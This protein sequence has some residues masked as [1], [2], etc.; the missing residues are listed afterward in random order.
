MPNFII[1]LLICSVAMSILALVYIAIIPLL[2]K[3]YSEK[4]CY[5]AW[6]VIVV[7]LIIPFRPQWGN[8][9]VSVEIPNNAAPLNIVQMNS[10]AATN[11]FSPIKLPSL[12][13]VEN[14]KITETALNFS[15]WQI[16]AAVWLIGL[17]MFVVY[18]SVKHY[19]FIKM[20][21]R[22]SKAITDEYMLSSLKSL[23]SEMGITKRI[24]IYLCSCVGSPV[25]IGLFNPCIFFPTVELAQDEICFILKHE[26][27]HYKRKDLLYKYLV[28]AATAIHWFNP[29]V[30]IIARTINILC[31]MSCDAAVVQSTDM[32]TRQSYSET[33][34]GVVKYHS[35]LKTALSTN[36]YGGRKGVIKRFLSIMDTRKKKMGAE[37]VCV[38]LALTVGTGFLFAVTLGSETL[39]VNEPID[40]AEIS[41]TEGTSVLYETEILNN[42][43][44]GNNLPY[45]DDPS[46]ASEVPVAQPEFQSPYRIAASLED[47]KVIWALQD[48]TIPVTN[49]E[50][51]E[52][53]NHQADGIVITEQDVDEALYLLNEVYTLG[54]SLVT[55]L[56]TTRILPQPTADEMEHIM[57]R[58]FTAWIVEAAIDEGLN[59]EGVEIYDSRSFGIVSDETYELV[60]GEARRVI[61]LND[62]VTKELACESAQR[63]FSGQ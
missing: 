25:M 9:L 8:A 23:K 43:E 46:V 15:W 49:V 44:Q 45:S 31:E 35:K 56:A 38:V 26:L 14:V 1:T 6:L 63:L 37:I 21:R 62:E 40:S 59:P 11:I 17:I 51:P 12:P 55:N 32:D 3:R 42:T 22:W 30:Y 18:H 20:V 19:H 7:G 48:G 13:P 57:L 50:V 16:V 5:Y 10:E 33:I 36:F 29:I 61:A 58:N 54:G 28:L 60:R 53:I 2:S 34:I 52:I 47:V 24:P 39:N 27:V 41:R 4:G